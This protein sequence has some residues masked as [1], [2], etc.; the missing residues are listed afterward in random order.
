MDYPVSNWSAI[1]RIY[2]RMPVTALALATGSSLARTFRERLGECPIR[3]AAGLALLSAVLL[4]AALP[5]LAQTETVLYSFSGGADGSYPLGHLTFD[6]TGNLYGTTF[7]GGT[8]GAGTVFE[9]S[10]NGNVGWTEVVL[11]SFTGGADGGNPFLSHVMFDSAG[12]L[13][14][15]ASTGGAYGYGAVFELSFIGGTWTETVLHSFGGGSDGDSP[16]NGLIIDTAGNLYGLT[17]FGG[18][19]GFGTVFELTPSLG[20]WTKKVIYNAETQIGENAALTID[21][22][23]NIFGDSLS[24]VF[25]LLPDTNGSWKSRVIHSFSDR[26]GG[27]FPVGALVFDKAGNLFGTTAGGTNKSHNGIVYEL[28]PTKNGKWTERILFRFT[29]GRKEGRSPQGGIVFDDAGNIFGTT[30]RGG[31]YGS[32]HF[33]FGG[34]VYELLAPVGKGSYKEKLLWS[35]NGQNGDTPSCSLI[36]DSAGRLYGTAAGGVGSHGVVFRVTP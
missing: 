35:F 17:N 27:N 36:L 32:Y 20:G 31:K 8:Y 21:G 29:Y 5:A 11:Y 3:A 15:T 23:G 22:A 7:E 10:P 6:S 26:R 16:I 34:T 14:G 24:S 30:I 9:L 33:V 4:G 25:E 12:N 1:Q 13:L 2:R 28:S 18:A 19:N